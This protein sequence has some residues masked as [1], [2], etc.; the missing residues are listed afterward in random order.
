MRQIAVYAL[1]AGLSLSVLPLAAA[2]VPGAVGQVAAARPVVVGQTVVGGTAVNPGQAV[3]SGTAVTPTGEPLASAAVRARNLL[4]GQI[5]G[6]TSTAAGG[7]FALNVNPGSYV[8]EIVDAGGQIVGTSSFIS[9]A[10]GATVT[11][12]TV[13]ATTGALSAVSGATGLLATLGAT[14]SAPSVGLAAAAAGVA[15][16][17][18]PPAVPI[19]S[20]SR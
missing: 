1:V 7:Q 10:A 15:G 8:L 12:A 13:T 16:V 3:I 18:V 11:T 9:A 19:A 4:T 20:P 2:Q 5:G 14:A 6:S 17:V